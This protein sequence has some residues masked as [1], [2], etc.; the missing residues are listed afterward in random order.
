MSIFEPTPTGDEAVDVVFKRLQQAMRGQ[1]TDVA[2]AIQDGDEATQ[3]I[4]V[5]AQQ[6]AQGIFFQTFE[7]PVEADWTVHEGYGTV[8]YPTNGVVG[9]KAFRSVGGNMWLAYPGNIPFDPARLYRF[10][11][12]ARLIVAP[13]NP[14]NDWFYYG[15]EGV[16]AD[17][18]TLVNVAG[19]DTY[20][21]QHYAIG[22]DMGA[23]TLGEWQEFT[24]YFKGTAAT[25][26]GGG[27][28]PQTAGKTHQ[29]VRYMRPMFLLNFSSGDG[30]ME[31]DYLAIEVITEDPE[32]DAQSIANGPALVAANQAASIFGQ[33]FSSATI[34][35][36]MSGSAI[37]EVQIEDDAITS[38][39]IAANTIVAG[40]IQAGTITGDRIAGNT[41]QAANIAAGTITGDEIAAG[42]IVAGNIGADQITSALIASDQIL[43]S[44]IAAGQVDTGELAAGAVTTTKLDAL[45]VTAAKIS[46]GAIEAGKIAAGAINASSLFVSGVVDSAQLATGAVTSNKIGTGA[47]NS[48]T[49]IANGVIVT[50]HMTSGSI[51]ADRLSAG[52]VDTTQLAAA[53]ITAAKIDAGA[54]TAAKISAGAV[55]TAKLDA[56]AVTTAKLAAG[57]VEADKIAANAIVAG[58]IAVGGV[59]GSTQIANGVVN[60]NQLAAN[61]VV[62]SKINVANLA[63]DLNANIGG[64]LYLPT[65][66]NIIW[67]TS[68]TPAPITKTLVIPHTLFQPDKDDPTSSVV[69]YEHG[70]GYLDPGALTSGVRY[71]VSGFYLPVGAEIV[72][73]ELRCYRVSAAGTMSFAVYRINDNGTRTT[74]GFAAL[75]GGSGWTTISDVGS[76]TVAGN[77][78]YVQVAMYPQSAGS[79][80]MAWCK[81]DYKVDNLREAL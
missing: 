32:V 18:T 42:T 60:T 26:V 57:A 38:P 30:T 69:T 11:A 79:H 66:N 25:G 70:T 7:D 72:K 43:A 3:I 40:N 20:T 31:I 50:N 36:L 76:E 4:A 28:T 19:A 2:Q 33:P 75:H 5:A 47:I 55:E 68:S 35:S 45:A 16:A 29:N 12:R 49:M 23:Y 22:A 78:Y 62:A 21:N 41:I 24:Y 1:A 15:F 46:A 6:Q 37:T 71:F 8:S 61:A 52:T 27:A 48:G 56:L 34:A 74:T 59:S 44:H 58:K 13:T 80:R 10:R 81:V 77:P 51:N 53:A 64:N 67:G 9:G 73:V 17:G 63:V 65:S 39:K 14:A 54:V